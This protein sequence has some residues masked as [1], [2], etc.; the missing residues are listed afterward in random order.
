[1]SGN[2]KKYG[3]ARRN[4]PPSPAAPSGGTVNS[5]GKR[6]GGSAEEAAA[7]AYFQS[8]RVDE[9]A[10]GRPGRKHQAGIRL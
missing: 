1:M 6:P 3:N 2:G 8:Q 10:S 7:I 5:S 4:Q 9:G